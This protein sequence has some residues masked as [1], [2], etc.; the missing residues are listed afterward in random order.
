MGQQ[1]FA[2]GKARELLAF[3]HQHIVALPLEQR[4]RDRASGACPNDD[5]FTM[6]H[7]S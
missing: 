4:G 3:Q 7:A 2:D 6:F 1:A 5:D